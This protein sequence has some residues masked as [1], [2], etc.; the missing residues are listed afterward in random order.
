MICHVIVIQ[1]CEI[2]FFYI[3]DYPCRIIYTEMGLAHSFS[4]CARY[5]R[6]IVSYL[7][8]LSRQSINSANSPK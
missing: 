3:A 1:V 2:V 8:K 6:A 4:R 5:F 7:N